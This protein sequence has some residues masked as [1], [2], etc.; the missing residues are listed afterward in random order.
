[1]R[2]SLCI[3]KKINNSSE[4]KILKTQLRVYHACDMFISNK[5]EVKCIPRLANFFQQQQYSPTVIRLD[6]KVYHPRLDFLSDFCFSSRISRG[7]GALFLCMS[8]ATA[9]R[10]V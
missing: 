5:V 6:K 2:V 8:F 4:I 1:M 10:G 7:G 3:V 9:R